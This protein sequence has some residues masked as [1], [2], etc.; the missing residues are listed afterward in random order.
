MLTTLLLAEGAQNI[1]ARSRMTDRVQALLDSKEGGEMLHEYER[2]MLD[3]AR[4]KEHLDEWCRQ[5]PRIPSAAASAYEPSS[6][7]GDIQACRKY[8]LEYSLKDRVIQL[9]R[10]NLDE[11]AAQLF[12]QLCQEGCT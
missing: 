7:R 4:T 8:I 12:G 3:F 6:H 1:P 11:I 5:L 10:K 9:A 2:D